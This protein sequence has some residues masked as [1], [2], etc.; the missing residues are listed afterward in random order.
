MESWAKRYGPTTAP[1]GSYFC[2]GIYVSILGQHG[3]ITAAIGQDVRPF[4]CTEA[5]CRRPQYQMPV[6][7]VYY[8][9]CGGKQHL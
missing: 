3:G 5:L 7:L 6:M 8:V 4:I 2:L 1:E 9:L